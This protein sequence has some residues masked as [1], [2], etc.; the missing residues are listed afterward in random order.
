MKAFESVDNEAS[1]TRLRELRR[2]FRNSVAEEKYYK[3]RAWLHYANLDRWRSQGHHFYY[4]TCG[5]TK[6]DRMICTC[7]LS[8]GIEGD[9]RL[10]RIPSLVARKVSHLELDS[11]QSL[12]GHRDSITKEQVSTLIVEYE[13]QGRALWTAYCQVCGEIVS[14]VSN[15]RAKS[16]VRAHD[17]MH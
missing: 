2:A 15:R 17:S 16:F 3:F 10:I 11:L 1:P 14:R 8:V 6:T 7:G 12:E 5:T 9:H 4:L 13:W